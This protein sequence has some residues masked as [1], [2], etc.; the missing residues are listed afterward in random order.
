M[1]FL[2]QTFLEICFATLLT[3]RPIEISKMTLMLGSFSPSQDFENY[4]NELGYLNAVFKVTDSKTKGKANIILQNWDKL[5]K[6]LKTYIVA[7]NE[8]NLI[9]ADNFHEYYTYEQN[10][11]YMKELIE[12]ASKNQKAKIKM[13]NRFLPSDEKH[14]RIRFGEFMLELYLKDLRNAYIKIDSCKFEKTPNS[15]FTENLNIYIQFIQ[16]PK[17]IYDFLYKSKIE[18]SD[19]E[20]KIINE[21]IKNPKIKQK[22]LAQELDFPHGTFRNRM[23]DEIYSKY[24]FNDNE[25]K[26][27][28]YKKEII[29]MTK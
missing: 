17:Q 28:Q 7:Y 13:I 24:P 4:L 11:F 5:E 15:L 9:P 14:K 6:D 25:H 16:S 20:I 2:N 26:F 27:T 23:C 8:G 10:L 21:I 12:N 29:S 3:K 19:F 1:Y 18:K 22:D